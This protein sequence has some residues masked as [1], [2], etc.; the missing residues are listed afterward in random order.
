MYSDIKVRL[1]AV[2]ERER[3]HIYDDRAK[4]RGFPADFGVEVD[5]Y[6]TSAN[7]DF[8]M[9]SPANDTSPESAREMLTVTPTA[10][11]L[12]ANARKTSR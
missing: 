8:V 6:G 12:E 10:F 1:N 9:L 11:H 3:Q 4:F 2:T 5:G 7:Q